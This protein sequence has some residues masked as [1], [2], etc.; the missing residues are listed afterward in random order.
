MGCSSTVVLMELIFERALFLMWAIPYLH[1]EGIWNQIPNSSG[2]GEAESSC[3][4]DSIHCASR[5]HK[6]VCAHKHQSNSC[7]GSPETLPSPNAV[8]RGEVQRAL[9][10]GRGIPAHI[11]PPWRQLSWALRA[12]RLGNVQPQHG[13][14]AGYRESIRSRS[15]EGRAERLRNERE[16]SVSVQPLQPKAERCRMGLI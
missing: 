3:G 1:Q 4:N 12:P 8:Q 15:V 5:Q 11:A 2:G 14:T 10:C 16:G 13:K 7:T 6:A 9:Q